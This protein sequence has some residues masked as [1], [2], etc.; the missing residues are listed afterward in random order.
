MKVLSL[1]KLEFTYVCSPGEKKKNNGEVKEAIT[2]LFNAMLCNLSLISGK[3]KASCHI[4]LG[5]LFHSAL[6]NTNCQY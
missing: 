5:K 2:S 3:V 6:T 4:S 1:G